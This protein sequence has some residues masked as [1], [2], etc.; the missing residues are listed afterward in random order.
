MDVLIVED[1]PVQASVVE[2]VLEDAG[3]SVRTAG[4]ANQARD[5]L[6]D[7]P[8]DVA[9]FDYQL[10]DDDG[11]TLLDWTRQQDASIPV[12][13]LTG[14]GSE[15]V[16][17]QALGRGAI[18]YIVKSPSAYEDLPQRL[19]VAVARW[20]EVE[21]ALVNQFQMEE[22]QRPSGPATQDELSDRF[23]GFT[24]NPAIEGVLISDLQ[25]RTVFSK[26]PDVADLEQLKARVAAVAHQGRKVGEAASAAPYRHT[27]VVQGT[28]RVLISAPGPNAT[29]VTVLLRPGTGLWSAVQ[30][31]AR[32]SNLV[33][34][35]FEAEN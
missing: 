24:Q 12:V 7:H 29:L 18:D 16:A 4:T 22:A 30:Y 31:L 15:E 14:E 3:W 21:E 20:A 23:T 13:F 8:P 35:A 32:A 17:L 25:G 28:E 2:Q 19:R 10:P 26:I 6:S 11:L 9:L 27:M 34:E 33:R 1:D 5:L